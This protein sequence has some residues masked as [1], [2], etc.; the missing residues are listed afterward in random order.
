MPANDEVESNAGEELPTTAVFIAKA[1]M[2][3]FG[4]L[5]PLIFFV[6]GVVVLWSGV[7]NYQR[8]NAS[9]SWP[10]VQGTVLDATIRDVRSSNSNGPSRTSYAVHL[11]YEY[12][13][14]GTVY[15]G[16]QVR[17]GAMMHNERS[18]ALAEQKKY[19]TDSPVSVHYNPEDASEAV[20]VAGYGDGVWVA[21]GL[22][23]VFTVVGMVLA[24]VVPRLLRGLGRRI[25]DLPDAD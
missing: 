8:G 5:M 6:V 20:L 13:V 17:F 4:R 14:D 21:I 11:D 19:A 7:N 24:F 3:M 25:M 2:L 18:G 10:T 1:V 23:V 22:G 9:E 15:E 16:D 12:E